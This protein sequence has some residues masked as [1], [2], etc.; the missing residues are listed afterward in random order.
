[1]GIGNGQDTRGEGDCG[2][3]H[4]RVTVA[5]RHV[6]SLLL[7][8]CKHP[9]K[10]TKMKAR[11]RDDTFGKTFTSPEQFYTNT[12]NVPFSLS[13]GRPTSQVVQRCSRL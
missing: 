9:A 11:G 1:M 4:C 3:G 5:G 2:G 7:R 6:K 8:C 10:P 12:H 13:I